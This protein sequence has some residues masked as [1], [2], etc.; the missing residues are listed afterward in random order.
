MLSARH[1][2]LSILALATSHAATLRHHYP[3]DGSPADALGTADLTATGNSVTFESAGGAAEGYA[4]LGGSDDYLL[5][6]LDDGSALSV[7]GD[8]ST[9]R[10]FS[11]TFWVR[12]KAAQAS[13]N[14]HSVIGMTHQF[15]H[16][17]HRF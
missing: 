16:L 4:R 14:T 9:F 7:L 5:A 2:A 6:S 13:A 8:Y 12:Q 17:Q 15:V 10:P 11:I 1:A 3:L